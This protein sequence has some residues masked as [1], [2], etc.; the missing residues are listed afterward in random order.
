MDRSRSV[1][2]LRRRT[3]IGLGVVLL[4]ALGVRLL[5]TG[6]G[7]P[8]LHHWDEPTLTHR[9]LDMLRTGD[10]NPRY[11]QYPSLPF[12]LF[13]ASDVAVYLHLA[14][15]PPEHPQSLASLDQ[16]VTGPPEDPWFLSHPTFLRANRAVVALLGT[17][18]VAVVFFLARRLRSD[19]AG[20]LAAL[21]LAAAEYPL[22]HSSFATTDIPAVACALGVILLALR[23]HQEHQPGDL[24]ASVAMVGVAAACKYNLALVGVAPVL[25][26]LATGLRRSRGHRPWLWLWLVA[27]PVVAFLVAMPYAWLDLRTFLDGV[28][29]EIRH[30]LVAGHGELSVP[31]GW[32]HLGWDLSQLWRY[33]GAFLVLPAVVGLAWAL[34][35]GGPKRLRPGWA[36]WIVFT[37]GLLQLAFTARTQ[38]SFHRNLLLVHALVALAFGLGVMVILAALDDQLERRWPRAQPRQRRWVR[39]TALAALGLLLALH[40]GHAMS[41]S[42]DRETTPETRSRAMELLAEQLEGGHLEKLEIAAELEVHPL[43]LA[44]LP[45]PAEGGEPVWRQRPLLDMACRPEPDRPVAVPARVDT[46]LTDRTARVELANR[47]LERAGREI[48]RVGGDNPT[49]LG[50]YSVHPA[51]VLR[52][53]WSWG[54]EE[55]Q[56]LPCAPVFRDVLPVRDGGARPRGTATLLPSGASARTPFFPARPGSW[57]A[58][59]RDAGPAGGPVVEAQVWVR[60]ENGEERVVASRPVQPK[61]Q[62]RQRTWSFEVSEADLGKALALRFVTPPAE[63][64]T[65]PVRVRR[66]RLLPP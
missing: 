50:H 14:G 22:L 17:V 13:A 38:V 59:W 54:P 25:A 40:A 56:P 2:R 23:F 6:A 58:A 61:A 33:A 42:W 11:F 53:P 44:R 30:Y 21:G 5:A 57:T 41:L 36:G 60:E 65:E 32:P 7:L 18:A 63:G 47:L 31:P 9:A 55:I 26:L 1:G 29:Y 45:P 64:A 34:A 15:Q 19:R 49:R 8:Y 12:Y 46:L 24:V 28:G 10:L 51:V 4:L 35:G 43:D 37:P 27:G 52:R 39:R 62:G 3:L 48:G 20:L 66:V 16:V